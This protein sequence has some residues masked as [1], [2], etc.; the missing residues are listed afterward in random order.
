MRVIAYKCHNI[1]VTIVDISTERI[2]AWKLGQ[3]TNL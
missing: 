2:K 1:K 3:I